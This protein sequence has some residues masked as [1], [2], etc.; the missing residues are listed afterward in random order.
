MRIPLALMLLFWFPVLHAQVELSVPSGWSDD[1]NIRLHI[2]ETKLNNRLWGAQADIAD[3]SADFAGILQYRSFSKSHRIVKA[4]HFHLTESRLLLDD[5]SPAAL[6]RRLAEIEPYAGLEETVELNYDNAG[7]LVRAIRNHAFTDSRYFASDTSTY[8]Y[9]RSKGKPL[10]VRITQHEFSNNSSSAST[11]YCGSFDG[12]RIV[13]RK[14]R[15]TVVEFDSA[16]RTIL[17]RSRVR[18]SVN[19]CPD[20]DSTTDWFRTFRYDVKG[21]LTEAVDSMPLARHRMNYRIQYQYRDQPLPG[22]KVFRQPLMRQYL[23]T[24]DHPYLSSIIHTRS[25]REPV[26]AKDSPGLTRF[27][28]V[29]EAFTTVRDRR[30]RMMIKLDERNDQEPFADLY[31]EG[32]DSLGIYRVVASVYL[33]IPFSGNPDTTRSV[34]DPGA[35]REPEYYEYSD[36][37]GRRQE[38]GLRYPRPAGTFQ[39]RSSSCSDRSEIRDSTGW[40]IISY[41]P[42][43]GGCNGVDCWLA[44]MHA[45]RGCYSATDPIDFILIDPEGELRYIYDSGDFYKIEQRL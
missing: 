36:P 19:D 3:P 6:A 31:Q 13:M 8:A 28:T 33:N 23:S 10:Q 41:G 16:G 38:S 20:Y 35:L 24:L 32:R 5:K 44:P 11:Q 22:K 9:K 42:S 45:E 18:D 27:K 7:Y 15:Q 43:E 37:Y 21:R 14:R 4:T 40:R 2:S 39:V 34:Y 25:Y 17:L 30:H 29:T 26:Y 1:M 12:G